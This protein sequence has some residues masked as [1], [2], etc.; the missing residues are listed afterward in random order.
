MTDTRYRVC[1]RDQTDFDCD[2]LFPQGSKSAVDR[3]LYR[4]RQAPNTP[5]YI[6]DAHTDKTPVVIVYNG[7]VFM[8]D[9]GDQKPEGERKADGKG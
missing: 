1:Y 2:D 3:A 6:F 7:T 4:S 5:I 9:H 8:P